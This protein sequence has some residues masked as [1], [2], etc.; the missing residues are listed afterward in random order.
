[1]LE[2]A[3]ARPSRPALSV[4][5]LGAHADDIEI[6]CGGTILTLTAHHDVTVH[7]VLLSA[8]GERRRE[9]ETSAQLFLARA[10][11]RYVSIASFRTSFFPYDGQAIKESFE[12]LKHAVEPDL[13][14]THYRHDLHQDHRLVSELTW[15]T[16]RN[17]LILEYEI[18]KYDGDLGAPNAFFPLDL[19]TCSRKIDYILDSFATQRAKHW[20]TRDLFFALL[21]LRGMEAHAQSGLAEAFYLRK[22]TLAGA[23]FE[24]PQ[25]SSR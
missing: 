22:L 15:N 4:L 18:P 23:S 3:F 14:F 5:C 9:A 19:E 17:H 1:M 8:D 20:F 16:F 2:L 21:R 13:I 11:E 24:G 7:W 12:A 6:G 25:L 10:K